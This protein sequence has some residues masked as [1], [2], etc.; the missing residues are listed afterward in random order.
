MKKIMFAALFG[1][2]IA[3]GCTDENNTPCG[4]KTDNPQADTKFLPALRLDNIYF[5]IQ[6][7]TGK[8]LR[9][10]AQ[11]IKVYN[12]QQKLLTLTMSDDSYFAVSKVNFAIEGKDVFLNPTFG[13]NVPTVHTLYI[14]IKGEKDT[15]QMLAHVKNFCEKDS[16][17]YLKMIQNNK[18]SQ[19]IF[20]NNKP[21]NN[22]IIYLKK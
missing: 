22:P 17:G 8:A 19:D 3:T 1:C 7:K 6:D 18:A 4:G 13:A 11:D 9:F 2:L 14:E 15:L 16:V 12:E 21:I 20:I 10:F 5:Q